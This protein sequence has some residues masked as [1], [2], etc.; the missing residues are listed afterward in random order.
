MAQGKDLGLLS[1]DF[2]SPS[3]PIADEHMKSSSH[4]SS[5]H[6]KTWIIASW[7]LTGQSVWLKQQD[8]GSV[9]ARSYLENKMEDGGRHQKSASGLFVGTTHECAP[10]HTCMRYLYNT[11]G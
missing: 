5:Q 2:S 1:C 4:P 6:G 11:Q 7:G 10:V 8:P 9:R 3:A